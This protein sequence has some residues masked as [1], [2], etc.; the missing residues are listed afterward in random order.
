ML[1]T[2]VRLASKH[3]AGIDYDAINVEVVANIQCL[4]IIP[5]PVDQTMH[6]RFGAFV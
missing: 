5:S 4:V 1:R 3:A 2:P 6:T